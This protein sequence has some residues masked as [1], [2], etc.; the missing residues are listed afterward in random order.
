MPI[1]FYDISVGQYLRG[2][3]VVSHL[4]EVAKAHAAAKNIPL[5]DLV[6]WRL[7]DDMNPF[8]FQVQ[9]VCV[10]AETF[11]K[12]VAHLEVPEREGNEK[13]FAELEALVVST[14]ELLDGID[15]ASI[16][17]QEEKIASQPETFNKWGQFTG[18][19]NLFGSSL[20]NFYFHLVTAYDILRAKGVEVAKRDYL[21]PHFADFV[22]N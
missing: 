9:Y 18:F 8:S 16:E 12:N 10:V 11:L 13:T 14:S 20:P 19:E 17:G 4:L 22:K 7:I 21:R 2:L 3:K 6:E 5:D 1:S 15:R